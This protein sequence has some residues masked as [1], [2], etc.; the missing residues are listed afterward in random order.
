MMA[1]NCVASSP[2]LSFFCYAPQSKQT[3]HK[4]KHFIRKKHFSHVNCWRIGVEFR[5]RSHFVFT[6]HIICNV[7]RLLCCINF[8][9]HSTQPY[10]QRILCTVA[11][12]V[13]PHFPCALNAVRFADFVK[14]SH[15][16]INSIVCFD[17]LCYIL[18]CIH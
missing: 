7:I 11:V 10:I 8:V 5:V 1:S 4:Q 16:N 3:Q 14:L 17:R 13:W 6:A 12:D 2:S 15:I 18:L 9:W